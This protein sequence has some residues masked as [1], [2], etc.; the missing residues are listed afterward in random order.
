MKK[1][2]VLMVIDGL[3]TLD[4]VEGNAVKQANTPVFDKIFAEYPNVLVKAAGESVGLPAGQMGNSE[5]GHL[6]IGAGQVVYTGLSLIQ[7]SIDQN[8][9][10]SNASFL[11]AMNHAKEN[12][13]TLHVMGLLS[14]G[15]IHSLDKHLWEIMEMAKE[16]EVKDVTLHVFSDGRDVAPDAFAESLND[17]MPRLEKYGFK[18]GSVSGR[19]FS[20]D[21]D[22]MFERT[23]KAYQAI[24]GSAEQKFTDIYEY[25]KEQYAA[26]NTDEF[27]E[28]A[29]NADSS[30]N[31]LQDN[32]SVIFFNFRPDRARQLAHLMVGSSSVYDV[33]P[34]KQLKNV[35]VVSMMK[36][37]GVE[38]D[39]AFDMMEVPTPIG[40]VVSEAGMKQLRIAETQKYAHVTFFMDG[41]VDVEYPGADRILVDSVKV[42]SFTEAPK[43]SAEGIA[44]ELIKVVDQY[45]L[46]IMNFA[47]PD[48]VGHTG[49]LPSAIIAMEELDL[50]V[51][52]ILDKLNEIG[53][54]LFITADHGNA[55][56]MID[57]N[58]G[59]ATKHTSSPVLF[60]CSDKTVSLK[61]GGKLANVAPTVLDYMGI[62]KGSSM[63]E[64]S[65]LI[66]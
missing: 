34:S 51:G 62:E 24:M 63:D 19:L 1:P 39:V 26:G 64:D 44:T 7:N 10:R 5:V 49:D 47:N 43:M 28:P 46:T 3:G 61:E 57:E 30:V 20:M 8:T 38:T 60:V 52:R 58:G 2:V 14:P 22:A 25:I 48:M 35:P 13:S 45:D 55:E 11:N 36:Y 9:F 56:I 17:L 16:Q 50:Q 54:T 29:I 31:F 53:G 21:R 40:K 66:K 41:G 18:L 33:K 37:E 6:N 59:P 12:N 4:K 42:K 15:G 23:E 27:I 65:I 32:D